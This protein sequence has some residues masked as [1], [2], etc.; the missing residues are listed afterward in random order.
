MTTTEVADQ[1]NLGRQ[2][3]YE[4]LE[5]LEDNGQLETK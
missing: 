5:R 2:S 3:T 4:R 1:I